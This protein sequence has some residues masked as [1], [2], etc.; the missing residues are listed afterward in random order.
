MDGMNSLTESQVENMTVV[1]CLDLA[2]KVAGARRMCTSE[3]LG[4]FH[5]YAHGIAAGARED[6]IT[7]THPSRTA[8]E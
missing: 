1:E 3:L 7:A 2:I 8:P 4:L 6:A 5:Y